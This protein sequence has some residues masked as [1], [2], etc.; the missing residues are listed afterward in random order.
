MT[1]SSPFF[2]RPFLALSAALIGSVTLGS[3]APARAGC[4]L[5]PGTTI[6]F[7]AA[8][9][10]TT[11]PYAGPG[12]TFEIMLRGCDGHALLPTAADHLVTVIFTPPVGEKTAVVL[13]ADGN[14]T[15]VNAKLGACEGQLG[16]GRAVCVPAPASRLAIVPHNGIP[17]VSFRFPDTDSRCFGGSDDGELCNGDTV[18][19]SPGTCTSSRCVGGA[20]DQEPCVGAPDCAMPGTCVAGAWRTTLTGPAAVA[21]SDADDALPCGVAS[22]GCTGTSGLIACADQYYADDGACGT[23]MSHPTFPHFTALPVPNDYQ[24]DCFNDAPP[25][26]ATETAVRYTTDAAGNVLMPVD[27]TGVMLPSAVPVPRLL[28][29]SFRSPYDFAVPDQVFVGSYTPEGGHLPPI[30]EPK[31]KPGNPVANTVDLSGSVDAPYTI[32]R[33]AHRHGTCESGDNAGKRC[34]TSADCLGAPCPTSCRGDETIACTTDLDCG[35]DG[36]CGELYDATAF[37]SPDA[38]LLARQQSNPNLGLCQDDSAISCPDNACPSGPCVNYA[39]QANSPVDLS[40]LALRSAEIR[41][42]SAIERLGLKDE[43]GDGD[44]FDRTAMLRDRTTGVAQPLGADPICPTPG[45]TPGLPRTGRA[46]ISSRNAVGFTFPAIAIEDDLMAMLESEPAQGFCEMSADGDRADAVLRVFQ[47]GGGERAVAGLPRVI[48]DGGAVID[49]DA[50]T[51]SDGLVFARRSE[52][53]QS[54]KRTELAG[55]PDLS[56]PGFNTWPSEAPKLSGDGRYV[57]FKATGGLY[58]RDRCVSHGRAVPGCTISNVVINS[59][60]VGPANYQISRNGRWVMFAS[61]SGTIV[62]PNDVDSYQ[63]VFLHDR[64]VADG[65]AVPGCSTSTEKISVDGG[66]GEANENS[67]SLEDFSAR[68]ARG[69]ISDD[70]RYVAFDSRATDIAGGDSGVSDV[71]VRDR[72]TGTTEL[73]SVGVLSDSRRPSMSADGRYVA[74]DTCLDAFGCSPQEVYVRDRCLGAPLGC[75]PSTTLV[76][77]GLPGSPLPSGRSYRP[78]ISAN[79]RYVCFDTANSQITRASGVVVRDLVTGLAEN[80]DLNFDGSPSGTGSFCDISA[81]GRYVAFQS[82]GI[83]NDAPSGFSSDSSYVHDRATGITELVDRNSAGTPGTA[84][85]LSSLFGPPALSDDGSVVA[86]RTDHRNLVPFETDTQYDTFVRG[87]DPAP[88]PVA[89]SDLDG[90]LDLDD[91]PLFV[92]DP[93]G[94]PSAVTLCPADAVSVASGRAAYVRHERTAKCLGGTNVGRYCAVNSEC[95]GGVCDDGAGSCPA[96]SL[97]GDSDT[98]DGV[99]QLWSPGVGPRVPGTTVNLKCAATSVSLSDTWVGALVSEAGEGTSLNGDPDQTDTVAGFHRIAGANPMTCNGGTWSLTG[100]AAE[101]IE[102]SGA[103][104]VI[105]T[106]EL[107][108]DDGSLNGDGDD[109]DRVLQV[110]AL[111]SGT[112]TASLAPCTPGPHTACTTGVRRAATDVVVGAPATSSCGPVQLVAFRSSEAAQGEHMNGPNRCAGG[113]NN[114]GLCD[115]DDDCPAGTCVSGDNVMNDQVLH[116]YDAESGLLVNTGMAAIP[117]TFDACDP[118]EPYRIAGSVV[119]YLTLE[120]DQNGLDLDGNGTTNGLVLQSFDF[121]AYRSSVIGAADELA[122]GQAPL[123]EEL[124]F[125]AAADRCRLASPG[126]CDDDADCSADETAFCDQDTCNPKT[127]KCQFREATACTIDAQCRRCVLR[128]PGACNDNSDCPGLS[129]SFCET[130]RVTVAAAIPDEDRDGVANASDNCPDVSNPD[131]ADA[132]A[133]DVGDACEGGASTGL[134]CSPAPV[135]NMNC[136]LAAKAQLQL[137]EKTAGKEQLKVQW[138][139][140]G[141]ATT[142]TSF[143]DDPVGSALGAAICVYGDGGAL[144]QSYVVDR[145][146]HLCSGKKCWKAKGTKGWGYGDKVQIADGIAKMSFGSGDVGKG[147]A[148]AQ[149]K[150]NSGKGLTALPTGVFAALTGDTNPTIQLVTS[151]GFCVSA[152]MTDVTKDEGGQF[153]AQ[154]K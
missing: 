140:F 102:V 148:S 115:V 1:F 129:T 116:V 3:A 55:T 141:A 84:W 17:H 123:H 118:R 117:C 142:Q 21:V 47:L 12:E 32:L 56:A 100:Q 39:F 112:G 11:R 137:S 131:Q 138:K 44:S 19:A 98:S 13:T 76:S 103:L 124:A 89:A 154:K 149:G 67:N 111:D 70:G 147:N 7:N 80:I 95:P 60:V 29:V 9:G 106:S 8:L 41:T 15:A 101:S 66:G 18:C 73:I 104:G 42:F 94:T 22:A 153:K 105:L 134:A 150:N 127:L 2:S 43:N 27:W 77:F 25:C 49:G 132:D 62:V 75:T 72:Q 125:T 37:A 69:V 59:T 28:Q 130:T 65:V 119:R 68:Q 152:T 40:S 23:S 14:C 107:A 87:P 58:V 24:A 16:A 51:I 85:R 46:V 79:G 151:D 64:C 90:D 33:I 88:T 45:I 139:G 10:A 83:V 133:N 110:Y 126:S 120:A 82:T 93:A 48:A 36:P 136:L 99:V 61:T 97:N 54:K 52:V 4:N 30:F 20:N 135:P 146:G 86:F 31:V 63:D 53:G 38:V 144:V 50:V 34:S 122:D 6:T 5:I 96:G 143:A 108:Q 35:L 74:F 109:T 57:V 113:M 121:C 128:Q 114:F 145:G 91:R 71:F 92:L 81:D 78:A 26:N